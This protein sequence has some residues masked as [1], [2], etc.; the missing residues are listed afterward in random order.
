M[1][2]LA[3][4]SAALAMLA[5][6]SASAQPYEVEVEQH[7]HYESPRAH[8]QRGAYDSMRPRL[9]LFG[10]GGFLG[11][12]SGSIDA[13]ERSDDLEPTWGGGVGFEMPVVHVFSIG[14]EIALHTWQMDDTENLGL[15]RNLFI[16]FSVEPRLRVPLE[17][18]MSHVVFYVGMPLGFS[19]DVLDDDYSRAFEVVGGDIDTGY[20]FHLGWR[21]G[22][23]FFV[24]RS[25]GVFGDIGS[26]WRTINHP[27]NL[28]GEDGDIEL[29][30][31]QLTA[32][33]GLSMGL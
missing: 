5:A 1:K 4:F 21:V 10:A 29:E 20:G 2:P 31:H 13:D 24:V 33:L 25:F 27:V 17:A 3:F 32:R 7:H 26:T 6:T 14:G 16:D 30:T 15:D 28:V 19:L 18:G 11:D 8:H 22:A 23:Q 12:A 9:H